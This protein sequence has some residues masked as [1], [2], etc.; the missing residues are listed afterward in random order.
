MLRG[1]VLTR[2]AGGPDTTRELTD[3]AEWRDVLG[4]T[5]GMSLGHVEPGAVSALW[6]RIVRDH[7]AFLAS[8][9]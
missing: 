6:E 3:E 7:E 5:F 1:R 4:D 9:A 8:H 2:S